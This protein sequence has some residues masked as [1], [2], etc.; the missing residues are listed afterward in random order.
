MKVQDSLGCSNREK[1]EFKILREV[2]STNNR[3]ADLG[4][5]TGLFRDLFSRIP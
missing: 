3:M 5:R 1:V 2:S 4:P